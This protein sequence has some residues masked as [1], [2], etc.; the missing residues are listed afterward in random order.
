MTSF[1]NWYFDESKMAGVDFESAAQVEVYDRNQ[2]ASTP[3]Y[4]DYLCIKTT[5]QPLDILA[6]KVL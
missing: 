3:T 4:A 1:P 5:Q 6:S 2:T